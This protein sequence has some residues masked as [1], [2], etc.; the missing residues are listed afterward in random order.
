MKSRTMSLTKVLKR[1]TP[2]KVCAIH[3]EGTCFHEGNTDSVQRFFK[4]DGEACAETVAEVWP[5]GDDIAFYDAA[6]LA[7]GFNH[8]AELMDAIEHVLAVS[9]HSNNMNDIDF[10]KLRRAWRKGKMVRL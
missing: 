6:L 10:G 5:A 1:T 9:E 4:S 7:H 2:G 3:G 8:V